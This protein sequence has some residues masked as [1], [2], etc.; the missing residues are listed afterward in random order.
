MANPAEFCLC[1]QMPKPPLLQGFRVVEAM[2]FEPTTPALQRPDRN[3][4]RCECLQNSGFLHTHHPLLTLSEQVGM[5]KRMGWDET[6]ATRD[7]TGVPL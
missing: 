4:I 3:I 6:A 2:G 1:P 5:G 7:Q